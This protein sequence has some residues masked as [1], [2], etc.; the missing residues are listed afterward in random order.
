MKPARYSSSAS[1]AISF[2]LFTSDPVAA[3]SFRLAAQDTIAGGGKVNDCGPVGMQVRVNWTD[4]GGSVVGVTDIKTVTPD[5]PGSNRGCVEFIAPV[6]IEDAQGDVHRTADFQQFVRFPNPG[7]T[8]VLD[9]VAFAFD[10]ADFIVTPWFDFLA[11]TLGLGELRVPDL[12]GD[13]DGS[14]ILDSADVLYAAVNLFPFVAGSP[15][16][17]LGDTFSITAGTSPLLPGMLFGTAPII[18]DPS[19]PTGFLNPSPYTGSGAALAEHRISALPEPSSVL[20]LVTG[21]LGVAWRKR[22]TPGP[23]SKDWGPGSVDRG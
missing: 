11:Q 9:V 4:A 2:I 3:A 19:S 18:R 20:L 7:E 8:S 17:Q 16:Y 6:K 15:S 5:K 13:T 22:R 23:W 14:G 1:W 21:L 12:F 10:G